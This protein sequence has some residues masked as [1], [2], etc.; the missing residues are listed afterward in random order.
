L[1]WGIKRISPSGLHNNSDCSDKGAALES[2][3]ADTATAMTTVLIEQLNIAEVL[4]MSSESARIFASIPRFDKLSLRTCP[5]KPGLRG[6][7]R[8]N[9]P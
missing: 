3:E 5:P 8:I 4:R 6:R 7:R 2:D 9:P 1:N